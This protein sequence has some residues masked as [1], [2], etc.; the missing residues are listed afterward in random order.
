MT[1]SVS[2]RGFCHEPCVQLPH[3][4]V[5]DWSPLYEGAFETHEA[6]KDNRRCASAERPIFLHVGSSSSGDC[7]G[8][9]DAQS[10]RSLNRG[11]DRGQPA[12]TETDILKVVRFVHGL[13][14]ALEDHLGLAHQDAPL[15][16]R[17]GLRCDGGQGVQHADEDGRHSWAKPD[18]SCRRRG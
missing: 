16:R 18:G 13:L 9:F 3:S 11:V 15:C 5:R 6:L 14:G 2:A 8:K 1:A 17:G 7:V 4:M 12:V 10:A